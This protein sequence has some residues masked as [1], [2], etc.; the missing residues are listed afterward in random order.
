MKFRVLHESKGRIRV[1]AE[2]RG[3]SFEQADLLELYLKSSPGIKS[4]AVYERTGDA[5]VL[6]DCDRDAVL[7]MLAVFS[8]EAAAK[9]VELPDVSGRGI[10]RRYSDKLACM[11]LG[12]AFA[13]AFFGT[14]I[15]A[16]IT[17]FRSVRLILK[18]ASCLLRGKIEVPVLDATSVAIS[19]VRRDFRTAS[20]IIFLLGIGEILE[21][22]THKKSV[23][24]LAK[25]MSLDV[26]MVWLVGEGE[27]RLV[28]AG[29]VSV[30]D[31]IAVHAGNLIPMDGIVVSGEAT[32]NQAS[33]TG[34]SIPVR[35][36][37]GGYVYAGTVVEEGAV[38]VRIEKTSGTGRYDRIVS[39]IEESEKLKSNSENKAEHLA[40]RL[41]PYTLG[42]SLLTYFL[43]RN[44]F[45]ALSVLM[46]DFSCALKLAM[47][48]AVLSAMRECS[49]QGITVKGGKFL[50]ALAEADT[51]VF[52]KTGT[53]THSCPNVADIVTF[54]GNDKD[55]MLR[56]AACLEEHYPHTVA[57][58]VVEAARARGLSHEEKHS[59]V[60]YIVAHGISSNIDGKKVVLGS[61]HFVFE[62]E[63][64]TAPQGEEWRLADLPEEFSHLYMA[65]SGELAA[66][67]CISAPLRG[68]AAQT[69]AYLKDLGIKNIVMMTGDN[70]NT[71]RVI[72]E[73]LGIDSYHADVLPEEKADF[74]RRE[75][76]SGR[77]VVM[78]GDG[79]NDSPALSEANVGIAISDGAAL[80]REVADITI[81]SDDLQA[82][83]K[84]KVLSDALMRR[85][86]NNYKKIISF[87]STLV[88]LGIMGGISP[89]A[90]AMLHNLS[91][92]AISTGSMTNLLK[93]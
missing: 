28:P 48:L 84:L 38:I 81:K 53:L 66:V 29:D 88:L 70:E 24:D 80:A 50:E 86:Y 14:P 60:E 36:T 79:I 63:G 1:H 11:F 5:V 71:A 56:L 9:C 31:S 57:N 2:C 16:V 45:K 32:V 12:R 13:G 75:R 74:V 44:A 90:S 51:I 91:T 61:R 15:K 69:I 92:L 46:V 25:I 22:W 21:E 34:E 62:D 54:G 3:M 35:K 37:H 23:S 33:L 59:D 6:Y 17:A 65:I 42:G 7:H 39:M 76:E 58:A 8:Y 4:A 72:A 77:T 49:Q 83:V 68:E 93:E 18:G 47:P 85:I 10:N 30:G 64:C 67:L 52:D 27:S 26:D 82:L 41:V 89:T 78:V 55:E 19:L 20:S 87:N 43:T 40:D 73:K